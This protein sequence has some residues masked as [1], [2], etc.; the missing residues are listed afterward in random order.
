MCPDLI[1]VMEFH[2]VFWEREFVKHG[3]VSGVP[4]FSRFLEL[5]ER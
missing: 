1:V 4:K 5:R 2:G 3:T